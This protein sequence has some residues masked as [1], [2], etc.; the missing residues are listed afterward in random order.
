[1]I[2]LMRKT[3]AANVG[4]DIGDENAGRMADDGD[5]NTLVRRHTLSVTDMSRPTQ[6]AAK[7]QTQK[8]QF[9]ETWT[10]ALIV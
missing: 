2:I 3:P 6:P 7:R 9:I 5:D 4:H 10:K 8:Q 1:M